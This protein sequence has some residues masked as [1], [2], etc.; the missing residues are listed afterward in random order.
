MHTDSKA[1]GNW[2]HK[3]PLAWGLLLIIFLWLSRVSLVLSFPQWFNPFDIYETLPF[4]LLLLGWFALLSVA[5]VGGGIVRLTGTSWRELGW[6][7]EGLM[8]AVDFRSAGLCTE[9]HRPPAGHDDT[10]VNG[11]T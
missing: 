2:F 3:H 9:L 7:R 1:D 11:S 8:K 6:R 5:L 4:A 10:R